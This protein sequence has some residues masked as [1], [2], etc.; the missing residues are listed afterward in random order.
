MLVKKYGVE[1]VKEESKRYDCENKSMNCSQKMFNVLTDV[2]RLDKKPQE[3][4]YLLAFDTKL[5]L[6]GTFEI[7]RGTL[8][9]T[10]V[11]TKGIFQRA[12]LCNASKIAVAHNHP[13]GEVEPSREDI[14]VTKRISSCGELMG[15]R[16]IDH[17]IVGD[18]KY[19]SFADNQML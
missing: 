10:V 16:L 3:S 9:Y 15:I 19:Y 14:S 8:D 2:F 12:L 11:D 6:I 7:G 13:S 4:F 1:L 5:R 18:G 17:I